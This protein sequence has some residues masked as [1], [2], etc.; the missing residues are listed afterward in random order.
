MGRDA[1]ARFFD[2]LAEPNFL[3]VVVMVAQ[4][5]EILQ[6]RAPPGAVNANAATRLQRFARRPNA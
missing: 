3:E 1:P 4:V 2:L 6:G 5:A